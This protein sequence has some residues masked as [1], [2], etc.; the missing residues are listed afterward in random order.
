MS[1]EPS[2]AGRIPPNDVDAEAAV[3]AAIMLDRDVIVKV[4]SILPQPK[5]LY[6]DAN[7]RIL[8][9][10]YDLVDDGTPVDIK[11]VASLPRGRETRFGTM[12]GQV[13]GPEYLVQ[14]VD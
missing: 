13:G 14:L 9:A 1:N 6:S 8:E 12:L 4:R 3:L 10:V 7:A 11:T 5:M 2:I